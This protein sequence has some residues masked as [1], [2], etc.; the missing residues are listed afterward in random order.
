MELLGVYA[1]GEGKEKGESNV[2]EGVKNIHSKLERSDPTTR[3]SSPWI[4]TSSFQSLKLARLRLYGHLQ[5]HYTLLLVHDGFR[6]ASAPCHSQG[7]AKGRSFRSPHPLHP[8]D[9]R[10][11]HPPELLGN[12]DH[13]FRTTEPRSLVSKS[14]L[15]C[16]YLHSPM[17]SMPELLGYKDDP[18]SVL[19]PRVHLSI[20]PPTQDSSMRPISTAGK[21]HA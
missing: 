13:R 10:A 12:S 16:R 7:S 20:P 17:E 9:I 3:H 4:T 18:P 11:H 21:V 14:T 5:S 19:K 1:L 2:R 6:L 15:D 8:S